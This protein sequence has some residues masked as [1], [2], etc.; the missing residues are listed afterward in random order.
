[1]HRFL[2]ADDED[3]VRAAVERRLRREGYDVEQAASLAE[4]VEKIRSAVPSFDV[5]ITDM[6]MDDPDSGMRVLEAA[7]THDLFS[8]VI[9]LTAYGNVANAV[10]CMKRGAFDYVEKNI[11]G[12]DVYE[13]IVLKV[14]QAL[15][16][17]RNSVQTV[18]RYEDYARRAGRTP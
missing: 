11:P 3:E 5:V 16:R 1:M 8:E 18:R 15:E 6:V 4:A 2:I 7:L 9:V 12:V 13:L 10:E 17:R 14:R